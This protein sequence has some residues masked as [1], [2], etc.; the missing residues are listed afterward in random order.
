MAA[1]VFISW[2]KLPRQLFKES[3]TGAE[4]PPV[5]T[6]G[7]YEDEPEPLQMRHP[8]LAVLPGPSEPGAWLSPL[9]K[10]VSS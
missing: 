2:A 10:A 8:P 7:L 1:A 9:C 5:L 4:K 6:E 3:E